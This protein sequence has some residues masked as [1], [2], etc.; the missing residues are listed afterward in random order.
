MIGL[1]VLLVVAGV[2]VYLFN[3]LVPIDG[4]FKLAINCVIG[5]CLF[6]YVVDFFFGPISGLPTHRWR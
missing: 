3:S 2:I 6:V 1:L 4:R 5:L